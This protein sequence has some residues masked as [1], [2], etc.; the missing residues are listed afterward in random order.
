M[1]DILE[2]RNL[3][4][5]GDVARLLHYSEENVRRLVMQKKIGH[6]KIG[7]RVRFQPKHIQ[8]FIKEVAPAAPVGKRVGAPRRVK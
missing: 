5:Y 6:I 3:L 8:A 1:S 2:I 7:G 4:D